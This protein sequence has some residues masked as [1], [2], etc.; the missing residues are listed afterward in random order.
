MNTLD[1]LLLVFL[2]IGFVVGL[3]RGFISETISILMILVAI[4]CSKW[5]TPI[6]KSMLEGVFGFSSQ[7]ANPLSYI[8]VFIG[9][10]V[11]FKFLSKTLTTIAQA[12]TLGGVNRILG[13]CIGTL[14][15]ALIASLVFNIVI[16]SPILTTIL[17]PKSLEV[18][19]LYTTIQPLTPSLWEEVKQQINEY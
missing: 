2:F 14:K 3:I 16:S 17:E 11:L 6:A 4:Y 9:I 7:T 10:I 13:A 1:I 5:L 18:S 8:L 12:A 19:K 15:H